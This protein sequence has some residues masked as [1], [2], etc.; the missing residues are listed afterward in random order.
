MTDMILGFAT[1]V[2]PMYSLL[3]FLFLILGNLSKTLKPPKII[4]S[5]LIVLSLL[6]FFLCISSDNWSV[7]LIQYSIPTAIVGYILGRTLVIH[8]D[9]LRKLLIYSLIVSLAVF[10]YEWLSFAGVFKFGPEFYSWD[11]LF[12]PELCFYIITGTIK[13]SLFLIIT[14]IILFFIIG[15]ITRKGIVAISILM[16][17]IFIIEPQ[18]HENIYHSYWIHHPFISITTLIMFLMG[19]W[20][21]QSNIFDWIKKRRTI[22]DFWKISAIYLFVY[23]SII[24][25]SEL[26]TSWVFDTDYLSICILTSV[27][28][29]IFGAYCKNFF[30]DN[31]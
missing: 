30:K 15:F 13:T 24:Q 16:I 3:F 6:T 19:W 5:I 10:L 11:S 29:F 28:T 23:H 2:I 12:N 27:I 26:G 18:F 7:G 25:S 21:Y 9:I 31:P 1:Y 22:F 17:T 4:Y 20:F 14:F 8:E